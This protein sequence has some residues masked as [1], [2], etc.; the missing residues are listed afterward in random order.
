MD[1]TIESLELQ[2]QSTASG[3]VAGIDALS[4]SLENLEAKVTGGSGLGKVANQL[5]KLTTSLEKLDISQLDKIPKLATSLESLNSIQDVKISPAIARQLTNIGT[6]INALPTDYSRIVSLDTALSSLGTFQAKGFTSL[7][8]TL[9]EIPSVVQGLNSLDWEGL[10]SSVNKLTSALK[11]LS[12]QLNE[13]SGTMKNLPGYVQ[14]LISANTRTGSS[15]KTSASSIN[16]LSQ[17]YANLYAK[18][19]MAITG[20]KAVGGVIAKWIKSSNTYVEDLNLFNTTLGSYASEAHNYAESVSELMGIDPGDFLRNEGT[21]MAITEGFGVASDQAYLMSKNLTQL[22]YDLSS[23]FNISVE[24]AMQKVQSGISGELEPLRR[25]G[26]DLSVARL[27]QDAYTLGIKKS[28]SSMTQAEKSQ[29]RY[30]EMLTQVTVAQGDMARTLDAPANQLR[31]LQAQLSQCARALGNIF[32]PAL[33]AVLPYAIAFVKVIRLVANSIASL[34]GFTLPEIDYSSLDK[35]GTAAGSASDALADA[36]DSAKKFQKTISGFDELNIQ[37][38]TSGSAGAGAYGGNDLGINL[39]SYDFIGEATQSRINEITDKLKEW[40]GLTGEINSFTDLLHTR[41]GRIATTVAAIGVS[42]GVWKLSVGLLSGLEKIQKLK[43]AGLGDPLT[44]TI[45]LS[46][47]LGG[48][49]LEGS[50]IADAIQTELNKMNFGQIVSGGLFTAGGGAI[51]GKGVASWI[52]KNLGGTAV[53]GALETAGSNLG[54]ISASAAG[55]A[56][57]A[58]VGGIIA[59]IPMYATGV[60]DALTNGMDWISAL[61]IPAGSTAAGAGIAAILAAAGTAV[62]PGV[63]TIIGLAVGALTDLAI[64]LAQNVDWDAVGEKFSELGQ[65]ISQFFSNAWNDISTGAGE[66]WTSVCDWFGSLADWFNENV[67]TPVANFFTEG[68]NIISTKA[69]EAWSAISDVFSTVSEWFDENLITPVS[70]F[71]S[72]MWTG[73][74][75]M[76]QNCWDK[77]V[78]FFSPA[79]EW[80]TNLFDEV[81]QTISDIFY[82]IGVIASGCWEI[83]QAAWSVVSDWFDENVLTPIGDFFTETWDTIATKASE[84][85]TKI[86]NVF[87]SLPEWFDE[88][89]ITPV[90]EFFVN[91]WETIS[92]KASEAWTAIS[93]AW[94]VASTWFNEHVVMPVSDF[95]SGLWSGFVNKARDAWEGVKNVFSKVGNFFGDIFS[96][97]WAKVV[98]VFSIGGEIFTNIKDG[99]LNAFKWVVNGLIRGINSVVAIPFNGINWALEKLR[100]I[101]ILGLTP[102]S[103]IRTINVPE[104][105]QLATGGVVNRGQM[106]IANEAGPELVGNVGN[107]TAVVN[108]DQIV[109]AVSEGVYKAVV[110]AMGKTNGGS[111][112]EIAVYVDGRRLFEVVKEQNQRERIRTGMNPLMV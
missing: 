112:G 56:L 28:V 30:Y 100:N 3:A 90:K 36:T 108:N 42:I 66:A 57:G 68:W 53:A 105:P 19:R 49:A 81:E 63:G 69:S 59:G 78:E 61:L 83:I 86:C 62:A 40:L 11:P 10:Q 89:I 76:A 75:T 16:I 80:F 79:I 60:Y 39:P 58:G 34:V 45:G 17:S 48:M 65:N 24:D 97:A 1:A 82:N 14:K 37:T 51:L 107:R 77:I 73:I 6:S 95:F 43:E 4:R 50:G 87:T 102:F 103:A 2:V 110:A 72:E 92:T 18:L 26:Y 70:T 101:K 35:T 104:I 106:F 21:F 98:E 44:M 25:L 64:I 71:F 93:E 33:N 74:S 31:I 22:G 109:S 29:L 15:A 23:F 47:T 84:A 8:K 5:A 67:T 9:G 27:Q 46:I 20:V 32:I 94:T 91:A 99:I 111:G 12:D 52:A 54:G 41:L 55:A 7:V 96:K 38:E 88:T 13:I 85:W